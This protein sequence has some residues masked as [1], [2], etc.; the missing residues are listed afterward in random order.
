[1]P[2]FGDPFYQ[3]RRGGPLCALARLMEGLFAGRGSPGPSRRARRACR[4]QI[5]A[6]HRPIA[7]P[8]LA[9]AY[10]RPSRLTLATADRLTEA[11]CGWAA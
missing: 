4:P 1:M 7:C 2:S 6:I 3:M 5:G 9:G 11:E 10:G 8:G